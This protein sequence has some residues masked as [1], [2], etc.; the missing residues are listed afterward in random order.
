MVGHLTGSPASLPL[1]SYVPLGKL[2]KLCMPQLDQ[3]LKRGYKQ[4]CL[5]ARL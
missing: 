4:S 3:R 2:L 5:L 1:T